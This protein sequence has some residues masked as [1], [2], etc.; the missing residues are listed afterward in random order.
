MARLCNC[1]RKRAAAVAAGMDWYEAD[2]KYSKP[3]YHEHRCECLCGCKHDTCGYGL[4]A[5][6]SFDEPCMK[7]R[8]EA[9]VAHG[10]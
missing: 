5:S 2:R 8:R 3:R 10:G 1:H 9:R 6:C 7:L 4:C